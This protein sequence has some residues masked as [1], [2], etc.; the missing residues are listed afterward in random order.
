LLAFL[1][2]TA[3]SVAD[4]TI[5]VFEARGTVFATLTIMLMFHALECKHLERSLFQMNLL[6]NRLLLWSALALSLSVCEWRLF[7]QRCR[8][9]ARTLNICPLFQHPQSLSCT[10]P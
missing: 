5:A 6:D 8:V 9:L 3:N 2:A 1:S 4:L 10:F 7:D